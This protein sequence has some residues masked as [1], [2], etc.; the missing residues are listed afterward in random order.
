MDSRHVLIVDDE[1]SIRH[2]LVTALKHQGYEPDTVAT[3]GEA[4]EKVSSTRYRTIICDIK[5]PD[6]DGL[7]L[8]TRI[9]E[10][11]HHNIIIMISAY[12]SIDTA[13]QA[14]K[15][16]A[17]DYLAKPFNPDELLL[18]MKK[19]E[20]QEE[21]R[22]EN[23]RLQREIQ[24]KYSFQ[25]IIG[26]SAPMQNLFDKVKKVAHSRTTIL[27]TGE[28]GTGKEL[29]ARAVHTH[30]MRRDRPFVPINCGAIP[31]NLLESE[32]FGH[33]RGAFTGASSHKR[34]LFEE[35]SEGSLFLDEIGEMPLA[36]QV[37]LF[38]VLQE[39][40]IRR[41]GDV[42]TI[43]T[44]VRIIAATAR[45]LED[46]VTE[47]SFREELFYRLN[48]ITVDIPPLRERPE[49]IPLIANHYVHKLAGENQ[50]ST[51]EISPAA[52][53]VLVNYHWPG[54]VRELV[55]VIERSILLSE[56]ETLL[57]GDLPEMMSPR[58]GAVPLLVAEGL[59][60]KKNRALLEKK[61]IQEALRE[62][63][64]NRT[65]AAKLLEISLRSLMYK[66]KEYG[67]GNKEAQEK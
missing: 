30:S 5:L 57:P 7:E 28:S 56:G 40:E 39:E 38:R 46:L 10:I 31:E 24:K 66:M 61:L 20:E 13:I 25:N 52:L 14:V 50:R 3:A 32:L 60:M 6:M 9:K 67:L 29:F 58:E 36:L 35:A 45:N 59:S 18:K 17:H 63:D 41:V 34:G 15:N 47:G 65:Q 62:A 22:E 37:K 64:Q 53:Q 8:L 33:V 4:I 49:D 21:L 2:M 12:G 54:N 48:V 51:R 42:K 27:I 43:K 16:G 26:K 55:N 19:G 1:P 44:D 23:L 11:D